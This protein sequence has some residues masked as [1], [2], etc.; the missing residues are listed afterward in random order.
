M[1]QKLYAFWSYDQYPYC[2]WGEVEKFK[3]D[4]VYIKY[5]QRW[6]K[7]FKIVEGDVGERLIDTLEIL[8]NR[9]KVEIN[10]LYNSYTEELKQ[11]LPDVFKK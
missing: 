2:L 10:K 6:V 5:Y 11:I 8:E 3:G 7:P 9:R 4:E 1:E